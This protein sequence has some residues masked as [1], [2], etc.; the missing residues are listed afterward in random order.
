MMTRRSS[1]MALA[2]L[3]SGFLV[4]GGLGLIQL[5]SAQPTQTEIKQ[6]GGAAAQKAATKWDSLT[7]EQQQQLQEKWKLNAEQ[8][9]AKWNA[10]TPEQQQQV[11]ARGKAAAQKARQ[12]WQSLPQ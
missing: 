9:Q 6:K 10:M 12:K 8:A 2:G 7:P 1:L 5:V 11:A 4:A 3:L